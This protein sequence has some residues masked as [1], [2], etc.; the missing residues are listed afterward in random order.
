MRQMYVLWMVMVVMLVFC[1]NNSFAQKTDVKCPPKKAFFK[2]K[3]P[4]ESSF[5]LP[6]IPKIKL[7]KLNI[8]LP[9]IELPKFSKLEMPKI[10]LPRFA[11]QRQSRSINK[12]KGG[13]YASTKCPK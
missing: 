4:K 3:Q 7:P 12:L 1:G 9:K 8:H 6:D 10:K 13:S 11:K 5:K 2:D